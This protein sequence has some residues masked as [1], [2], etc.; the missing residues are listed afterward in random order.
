VFR[1][2]E[3]MFARFLHCVTILMAI[4]LF[5]G[6]HPGSCLGEDLA[7]VSGNVFHNV[8]ILSRTNTTLLVRSNEGEAQI[9]LTDLK[10]ADRKKFQKNLINTIDLPAITVIAERKPDFL[11][12]PEKTHA[13][14]AFEKDIRRQ[15]LDRE[16]ATKDKTEHPVYKPFQI[17]RAI[18]FSLSN[19][20]I[21]DDRATT[22]DYL[23]PSYQR[24]SP[25]IVEKDLKVYK[26]SLGQP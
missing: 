8:E 21:N 13:E 24:L 10:E 14:T 11:A 4:L 20:G 9:P 5:G 2:K 17:T 23:T 18:S 15:D 3:N 1:R 16:Q 25:E 7:T 22:P 6:V 12:E 26:M 19:T